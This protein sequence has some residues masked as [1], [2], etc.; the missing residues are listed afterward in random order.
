MASQAHSLLYRMIVLLQRPEIEE[1]FLS[2]K[3]ITLF[4]SIHLL[5]AVV[6]AFFARFALTTVLRIPGFSCH[7]KNLAGAVAFRR[8]EIRRLP[9]PRGR[10]LPLRQ[11][12]LVCCEQLLA[13]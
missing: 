7:S 3:G 13:I 9:R 1:M 4:G 10:R 11:V 5:G 6:L 12:R 8:A 2:R